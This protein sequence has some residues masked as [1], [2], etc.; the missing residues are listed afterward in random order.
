MGC[1]RTTTSSSASRSRIARTSP[2]RRATTTD[3]FYSAGRNSAIAIGADGLGL[4]AYQQHVRRRPCRR[5]LP[6]RRLLGRRATPGSTHR[7]PATAAQRSHLDHDRRRRLRPDQL[8]P[9]T[10]R[11]ISSVAH[12]ENLTCSTMTTTT[13]DSAGK[14]G[15]DS[16][17]TIGA[18]GLGLISYADARRHEPQGRSLLERGLL[19]RH[20]RDHRRPA[21]DVGL[22]DLDRGRI[23][24]A[25]PGQLPRRRVGRLRSRWLTATN[26][27]CSTATIAPLD[28]SGQAWAVH[29]AHDR[30]RRPW[31][32]LLPRRPQTRR[33]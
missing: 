8:S 26:T 10:Q 9:T 12:C 28:D 24:R 33:A 7:R 14:V 30:A 16:S 3:L 17:I 1:S 23:R 32:D 21:L 31:A 18:D 27:A 29:L 11:A 5:P 25:R 2:A 19:R 15:L 20:H 4:I 6:E 13:I 22:L